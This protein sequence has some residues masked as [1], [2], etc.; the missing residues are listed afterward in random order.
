M[1]IRDRIAA[2]WLCDR[3]PLHPLSLAALATTAT[4]P[5]LFLLAAAH[6][7][8]AFLA[9]AALFGLLTGGWVAAASPALIRYS[10]VILFPALHCSAD[11]WGRTCWAPPSERSP[12]CAG[13]RAWPGRR[14]PALRWTTGRWAGATGL[15]CTDMQDRAAAILLSGGFMTASAL[16]FGAATVYS[17]WRDRAALSSLA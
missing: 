10:P 13:R 5:P 6:S 9:C 8:P 4:L 14:W 15:H 3:G 2:G 12:S 7:L 17:A 11:C 16:T 1:C